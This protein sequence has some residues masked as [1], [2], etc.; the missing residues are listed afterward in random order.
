MSD[1]IY[2][3]NEFVANKYSRLYFRI[4]ENR[5]SNPY[6]GHTMKRHIRAKHGEDS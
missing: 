5:L 2:T 4:I 3:H 6:E 1:T